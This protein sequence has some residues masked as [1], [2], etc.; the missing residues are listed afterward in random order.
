MFVLKIVKKAI[1]STHFYQNRLARNYYLQRSFMLSKLLP[2]EKYTDRRVIYYTKSKTEQFNEMFEKIKISID[3]TKRFQ[4]WIDTGLYFVRLNPMTDNQPPMYGTIIDSSLEELIQKMGQYD[5]EESNN[6]KRLLM[7]VENYIDRVVICLEE[8]KVKF[9]TESTEYKNICSSIII[10]RNMKNEAA[11]T[12]EEAFQRILFWQSMFWQSQH[13]LMGLGRLDKLLHRF[14]GIGAEDVE[15]L[16]I[17]FFDALHKY[18]SF[19]SSGKLLG[20]TG[21]IIELGGIEPDGSYYCNELTYHFIHALMSHPLPDP[22][23]LLRVSNKM[24]DDLLQLAI[25]CNAKGIGCPLLSNDDIV[26]PAIEKFGYSHSDACDYVTSACWEPLIY[27]KSLEKNNITVLNYAEPAHL[28]CVDGKL[29][30][31]K[32]E[33]DILNLYFLYLDKTLKQVIDKLNG[34]VWEEDPLMSLFVENCFISGKDISKGGAK[35]N[36]YGVLGVGLANA[37]NS[38]LN[39]KYIILKGEFSFEDA[40]NLCANNYANNEKLKILVENSNYFGR[41]NDEGIQL[42]KTITGHVYCV[43]SKYNNQFGGKVKIGLSASNYVETGEETGAT[44]DGRRNGA[45]LAVHISA[46]AGVAYTELIN[47]ASKLC[48]DG[49]ASNGNVVDFFVSPVLVTQNMDKFV[50]FIK[51]AIQKGFFQIQLNVLS[52]FTLM[53]A[54]RY[55]EK[56]PNLIVRV[57]GFSAYFNDL[58]DNYKELLIKRAQESEMAG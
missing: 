33:E 9:D 29:K 4:T 25:E 27:G 1:K 49:I 15:S 47:F 3:P 41:E 16:I 19:K 14:L 53:E 32:T 35:Y 51:I 48:Y 8:Y 13:V 34:M 43:L 23:I 28:M 22:K 7:G 56:Y 6:I 39:L 12:M 31:C 57:W 21:Q 5:N 24:P 40:I 54:K 55:P 42:I 45:P 58:P 20:D 17:E 50:D 10:F 52:S 44:F 11:Q 37:V 2:E 38:L 18:F 46:P 36:N 26:I 30:E